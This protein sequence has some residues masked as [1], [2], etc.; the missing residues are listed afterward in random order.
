V[1]ENEVK[2]RY[3]ITYGNMK[4]DTTGEQLIKDFAKFKTEVEKNG[5]KMILWGHPFGVSENIV[6]VLDLGGNM[7]N[8]IKLMN[9]SSPY[10]DSRTDFV[11]ER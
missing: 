7:D 8:Y 11:L 4:P 6:V 1:E 9:L 5:I 10:T 2:W 3:A